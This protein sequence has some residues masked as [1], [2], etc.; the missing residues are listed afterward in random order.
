MDSLSAGVVIALLAV[1]VAEFVNGWT[2]APNAIA[3]VVSTGVMTPRA[4]ILMAVVLNTLG[5]MSGTAVATTV[6]QGIVASSALTIPA[7]TATMI[8]IIC[9]GTMAAKLGI[10]VSKSHA[11]LAGLAGAG[12]AGGGLDALQWHGWQKVGIGMVLSLGI[13]FAGAFLLARLVIR[14]AAAAS[15]GRAKRRFDHLQMASAAFM[16]FNHGLNDG[17]K[18]MGVF[19]LTL[20][21]GGV[22]TEFTIPWWVILVCALTMGLGTSA[23]GWRIIET[24]G[25]KMTR[26][27]SWQGFAATAA[28]SSTIFGAS[29]YGVPLSTTHTITSAIIGV[30]AGKRVSDIR[31]GVLRKIVIAWVLTFPSCAVIAYFAALIANRLWA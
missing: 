4:A 11:L 31:W 3:T 22:T 30:G 18:F 15:P 26:L 13:G 27:T 10:P 24:V 28:A 6:G 2:D 23:G 16:A 12:F 25:S 21:A 29:L 9:W 7:I 20:L 17:Q 1:L 14:V 5:A 8:A 19:A